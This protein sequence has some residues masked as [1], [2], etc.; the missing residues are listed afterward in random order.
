MVGEIAKK[1]KKLKHNNLKLK[2][3]FA[4]I[5]RMPIFGWVALELQHTIFKERKI[6]QPGYQLCQ[7]ISLHYSCQV[8]NLAGEQITTNQCILNSI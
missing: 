2:L 5:G 6:R 8:K 3:N 4:K 1:N 7:A